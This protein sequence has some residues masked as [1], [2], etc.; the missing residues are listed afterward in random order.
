MYY[1]DLCNAELGSL[2]PAWTSDTHSHPHHKSL[3]FPAVLQFLNKV[4]SIS[5]VVGHG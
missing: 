2:T 5:E 4:S 1:A 3:T